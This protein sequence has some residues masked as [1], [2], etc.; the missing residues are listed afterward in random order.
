MIN[1]ATDENIENVVAVDNS[2]WADKKVAAKR[3]KDKAFY[4]K[5]IEEGYFK[6]YLF[7]L[8]TELTNPAV[9]KSGGRSLVIEKIIGVVGLYDYIQVVKAMSTSEE[10]FYAELDEMRTKEE[11]R[12]AALVQ[13]M[14]D[15]ANDQDFKLLVEEGY[16][17]DYALSRVSQLT[18]DRIVAEGSRSAALEQMSGISTLINYTLDSRKE[19]MNMIHD[20]VEA[21]DMEDV[22]ND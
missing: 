18:N 17:K 20:K 11:N 13:A 15:A 21:E 2:Y 14:D 4:K 6:D 3:L 10:E 1:L 9:I 22:D 19:Y 12:L 8:A 16:L 7:H 5:L